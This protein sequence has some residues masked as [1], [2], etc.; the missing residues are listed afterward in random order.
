[1]SREQYATLLWSF[2][3]KLCICSCFLYAIFISSLYFLVFAKLWPS[4]E[5]RSSI[6]MISKRLTYSFE[7]ILDET[8]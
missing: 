8:A 2:Y 4:S 5:Y 3:L 1:M 7:H 6:Q